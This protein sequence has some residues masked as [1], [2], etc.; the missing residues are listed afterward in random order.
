MRDH[1][2][3]VLTVYR[4][5]HLKDSGGNLSGRGDKKS[6]KEKG[7]LLPGFVTTNKLAVESLYL[8]LKVVFVQ[9]VVDTPPP[10]AIEELVEATEGFI[11]AET[12]TW[13]E[14]LIEQRIKDKSAAYETTP[15]FV[16]FIDDCLTKP[17]DQL[18]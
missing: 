5:R 3:G 1:F 11:P 10:Y 9:N 13:I 18:N 2:F 12:K 6:P 8:A 16:K 15:E 7:P 14:A 17:K 4:N